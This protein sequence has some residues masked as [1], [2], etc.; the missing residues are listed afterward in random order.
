MFTRI[1]LVFAALIAVT[2][3]A[4]A[5]PPPSMP[6]EELPP[7][8]PPEERSPKKPVPAS[9]FPHVGTIIA[10]DSKEGAIEYTV[11]VLVRVQKLIRD[12]PPG[13]R[14]GL[15]PVDGWEYRQITRKAKLDRLQITD[16]TGK[17]VTT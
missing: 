12:E 7:L 14:P 16:A 15:I 11:V 1:S 4:A 5:C 10:L 6:S 13:R 2:A 9:Q 17:R 3:I 8:I